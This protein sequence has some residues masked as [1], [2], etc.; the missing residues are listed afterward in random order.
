MRSFKF[1]NITTLT[2]IASF[3]SLVYYAIRHYSSTSPL[4]LFQGADGNHPGLDIKP[5]NNV[6]GNYN[7]F[8]VVAV[9]SNDGNAEIKKARA[10]ITVKVR[11]LEPRPYGLYNYGKPRPSKWSTDLSQLLL[12]RNEQYA[13]LLNNLQCANNPSIIKEPLPWLI[14][15]TEYRQMTSIYPGQRV[16]STL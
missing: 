6:V 1:I 7:G 16:I 10:N 2:S 14:N 8:R 5:L 12:S 3:A 13:Q 4:R 15:N 11:W 9:I